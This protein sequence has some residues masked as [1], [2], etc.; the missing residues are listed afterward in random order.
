LNVYDDRS[1]KF[2]FQDAFDFCDTS[3][4]VAQDGHVQPHVVHVGLLRAQQWLRQ[5]P[6]VAFEEGWVKVGVA[7]E[8]KG[9]KIKDEG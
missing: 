7:I 8:L 5:L 4:R 3:R 6:Q 1:R 9:N 2:F